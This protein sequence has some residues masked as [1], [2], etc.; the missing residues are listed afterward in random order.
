[1]KPIVD[2]VS[3]NDRVAGLIGELSEHGVEAIVIDTAVEGLPLRDELFR[4]LGAGV[5][6]IVN[7]LDGGFSRVQFVCVGHVMKEQN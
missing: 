1:M 6:R 7:R 3:P 5:M 2:R 4:F